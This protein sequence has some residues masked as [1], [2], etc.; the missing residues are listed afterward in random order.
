MHRVLYRLA[1]P[2]LAWC[3][4][5]TEK[6]KEMES[7]HKV[8]KG[9]TAGLKNVNA[10]LHFISFHFFFVLFV[11]SATRA[12]SFYCAVLHCIVQSPLSLQ[13]NKSYDIGHSCGS[14]NKYRCSTV[15]NDIPTNQP[16][17][18]THREINERRKKI[19]V[20]SYSTTAKSRAIT[21]AI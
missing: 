14:A 2:G 19:E 18:K 17:K 12:F 20:A 10:W 6:E 7:Q 5:E 4:R 21:I 11:F 9:R 16:K 3:A 13:S 15:Q 1:W 8:E